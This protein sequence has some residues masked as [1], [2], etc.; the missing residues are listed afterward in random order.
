MIDANRPW[1]ADPKAVE[2]RV[3][4]STFDATLD[5]LGGLVYGIEH[6][7]AYGTGDPAVAAADALAKLDELF[8]GDRLLLGRMP[9]D[10]ELQLALTLGADG[11]NAEFQKAPRPEPLPFQQGDPA[12]VMVCCC[13][14]PY[15]DHSDV[16]CS[17]CAHCSSFKYSHD[18][19]GKV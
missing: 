6:R 2:A 1:W 12:H 13:S 7:I 18:D 4:Q 16:G 15:T 19:D 11:M 10:S 5:Y 9:F 8:V 14:H 3:E 17:W